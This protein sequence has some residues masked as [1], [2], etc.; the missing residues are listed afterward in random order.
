MNNEM[1]QIRFPLTDD[2]EVL[3]Q[4]KKPVSIKDFQRIKTLL[5]IS[6][7]SIVKPPSRGNTDCLHQGEL[8]RLACGEAADRD[9]DSKP[10]D[11]ACDGKPGVFHSPT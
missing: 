6:E 8:V 1:I 3:I 5:E 2:N 11:S 9:A 10:V 7:E 4:L